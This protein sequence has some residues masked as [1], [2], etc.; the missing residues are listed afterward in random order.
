MG[1]KGARGVV[2]AALLLGT[3]A[4]DDDGEV[5]PTTDTQVD[6]GAD[7]DP[8]DTIDGDVAD[9]VGPDTSEDVVE[10]RPTT[11]T[12]PSK[13]VS[14]ADSVDYDGQVLR[15]VLLQNLTSYIGGLTAAIDGATFAPTQE[16]EVV[17]ALDFY[18]RFD[19]DS[20]GDEP[21][22]VSTTPAPLQSTYADVSAGRDIVGKLAGNDAATDHKDWSTEFVGWSDASIAA[23]G[24]SITSPEGLVVAFFETLEAQALARVDGDIPTGTDGA[25]LPVYVTPTG[26]D[27]QQLIQKTLHGALSFS[28]A[29]DDYLDS[30]HPGKGI[31]ASN[32]AAEGAKYT[33]L[34]HGWDEGFGYWGAARDYAAYSDEELAGKGGDAA[35]KL[36]YFDT[37]GDGAV[38]LTQEFNWGVSTNAAKRDLGSHAD[39][40]TDFTGDLWNAFLEGRWIIH[41]ADGELTPDELA[42]LEAQRDIAVLTWEKV[43][44]ATVVHY[45]NDTLKE[46]AK[47]DT[48]AYS[49]A[50]HAKGWSEMKGFALA[51]Q[52]NPASPLSDA[53]FAKFHQLVGDAPV[54]ETASADDIA[55]YEADLLEARALLGAAYEFAAANLG[56]DNGAGGW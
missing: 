53:D 27:L 17:A 15:Q 41:Q 22:G 16:G 46:M 56:D 44:A 1:L 8:G 34:G 9:D 47:F 23:H 6:T 50:K 18:F 5:T 19:G 51:F 33:P 55:A 21:H 37:D 43:I 31:L 40:K 4:C 36:G 10:Q 39:A 32:V 42:A 38:D 20:Y 30:E 24:G 52:F 11:Y 14:G 3:P 12:F 35:R 26:L 48:D 13:P 25:H 54:L 29:A 45:I 7:V 28:Q 49:F 2:A